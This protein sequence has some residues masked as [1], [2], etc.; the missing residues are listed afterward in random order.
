M[1]DWMATAGFQLTTLVLVVLV[2][3]IVIGTKVRRESAARRRAEAGIK[4]TI[5]EAVVARPASAGK[6]SLAVLE[7]EDEPGVVAVER[8]RV[9]IGRH[10]DDDIQIKDVTVSRHHALLELNAAGTFEI[11]NQT[12]GRSEPNPVLVNGVHREH[13]VLADGDLVTVGGVTFRFRRPQST[14]A[15]A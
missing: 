8:A 7:F 5:P 10:S 1:L 13:A 15:A 12:A 6:P 11:R 9:V 2:I 4:A 14:A 3:S